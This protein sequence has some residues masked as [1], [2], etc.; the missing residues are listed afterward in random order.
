[1]RDSNAVT[2]ALARLGQD[3]NW[4]VD[5]FETTDGQILVVDE[6]T[7]DVV[8]VVTNGEVKLFDSPRDILDYDLK[9]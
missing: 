4:E 1:M 6:V 2:N 8:G 5:V 3:K 9:E 7:Q